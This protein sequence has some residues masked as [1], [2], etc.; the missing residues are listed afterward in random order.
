MVLGHFVHGHNDVLTFVPI[1]K[2]DA[3]SHIYTLHF[4]YILFLGEATDQ[5]HDLCFINE[6]ILQGLGFPLK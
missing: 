4:I 6:N 2:S 5:N 1:C 3:E